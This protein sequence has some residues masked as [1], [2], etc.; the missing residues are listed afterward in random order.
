MKK[1]ALLF[2]VLFLGAWAVASAQTFNVV[3]QVDMT[4]QIAKGAFDPAADK[5]QARGDFN[6]WGTTDMA[7]ISAGSKVYSATIAAAAGTAKYKFFFKH[8]SNDVWEAIKLQV[9]KTVSST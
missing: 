3:F 5:V 1:H 7:P 4:V 2:A 6:N 8:G 9:Q